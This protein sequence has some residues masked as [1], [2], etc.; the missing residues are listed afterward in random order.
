MIMA[1]SSAAPDQGAILQAWCAALVARLELGGVEVDVDA[2]LG[3]AGEVAHAVIRPAAPLT[4]FV[5]GYAAGRAV[6]SGAATDESAFTVAAALARA[7]ARDFAADDAA[8]AAADTG[9]DNGA[10]DNTAVDNGA[11]IDPD[12]AS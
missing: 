8:A 1:E 5:V 7:A 6:E 11:V 4:A 12:A 3:L 2:V 10:G 9:V